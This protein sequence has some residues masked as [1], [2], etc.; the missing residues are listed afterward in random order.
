M[1]RPIFFIRKK[2]L[3]TVDCN[4]CNDADDKG[5]YKVASKVKRKG[6]S[7]KSSEEFAK[8]GKPYYVGF[9]CVDCMQAANLLW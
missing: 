8:D 6:V 7:M 3:Y 2:L 1:V 9:W 5:Y 4:R